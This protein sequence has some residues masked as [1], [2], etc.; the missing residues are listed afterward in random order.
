MPRLEGRKSTR[1]TVDF[2]QV[3]EIASFVYVWDKYVF[4]KR[5]QVEGCGHLVSGEFKDGEW[6]GCGESA[7]AAIVYDNK[8]LKEGER[9]THY[10]I[11]PCCLG[12]LDDAWRAAHGDPG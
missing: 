12:K 3:G 9:P 10:L 2:D 8:P 6:Q 1:K 5:C 7:G 11:C 4:K